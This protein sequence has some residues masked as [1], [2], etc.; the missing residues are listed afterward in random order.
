M[1][2]KRKP[3]VFSIDELESK[4]TK[5]LLGYLKKLQQCEESF[6]MS[7]LL[8]NPDLS[9][10]FTI[11]FKQTS[12]WQAAYSDVKRILSEREHID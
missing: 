6:E 2:K 1:A 5:E 4:S 7:D 10:D 9:D 12:K 8:E 11:Y 3:Q